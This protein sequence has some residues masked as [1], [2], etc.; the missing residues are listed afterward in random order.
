MKFTVSMRAVPMLLAFAFSVGCDG[1]GGTT[2]PRTPGAVAIVTGGSQSATVGAP[3][4]AAPS[5]VVTDTEGRPMSGVAVTFAVASGGGSVTGGSATTNGSGVATAGSWTLGT[6]AGANSLT[7]SAAGLPAVTFSATGIAGPPAALIVS[8]GSG[9]AAVAGSALGIAPAVLVRD[10]FANPVANVT[11][12]FAVASGS[13]S[14]AQASPTTNASGIASTPWILGTA[15]GTNTMNVSAG[16]LAPVTIT[17]TGIAGTAASVTRTSAVT[18]SGVVGGAPAELPRA[19][20]RDANGNGVANTPVVF[21]VTAGGGTLTGASATTDVSGTA[22]VGGWTLGTIAG[23]QTVTAT[24]P[25]LAPAIFTANA[26]PGAPSAMAISAAALPTG[27]AGEPLTVLPAVIMRDAFGN[28]VPNVTVTFTVVAGGGALGGAAPSTNVLGIATLTS[29]TLGNAVGSNVVRASATGVTPVN[30]TVAGI[31]GPPSSLTIGAGNAQSAA[32][33]SAVA[34]APSVFLRDRFG[35]AVS[36]AGVTFAVTGG[37]GAVTGA[38]QVTTTAGAATVGSWTLGAVAGSNTLSVQSAGV[39]AITFT[40]TGTTSP[41]PAGNYNITVRYATPPSARQQLAVDRAVARWEQVI[42]GDLQNIPANL[43]AGSCGA[44]SAALSETIDDLLIFVDFG[45][46]DGV[47]QILGQAGPCFIRTADGLPIIGTVQL[48]GADL[49]RLE[50]DGSIDAVV[51]HEIGHVLGIGSLWEN[52]G[53]LAFASTDTVSFTGVNT[54]TAFRGIPGNTFLGQST[55]VEN[56]VGLN[57]CGQG[58][59]DSHWRELVLGRELMTGFISPSGQTN[60]LSLMT[61]ESLGDMGYL[62]NRGAADPFILGAGL[63]AD[64]NDRTIELAEIKPSFR[65]RRMDTDGRIRQ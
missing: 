63:W 25:G 33:G 61:I 2:A 41:L 39:P 56:C 21:A 45:I 24:A 51:L 7:A 43:P 14:V 35:N 47:G 27:P 11:V 65:I 50:A 22:T 18:V 12:S 9:Q 6:S 57:G 4:A 8:A 59:R 34:I 32:P 55:P 30:F 42:T 36:N 53:L 60:P 29:W 16:T 3:V 19:V 10:A 38:T 62:V 64:G 58:T 13:G 15:A 17:A 26:A 20:V 46:I 40:A 1:G 23:T 52:Q 44:S 49:A 37:G 48:D 28:P 31:A 5:V 54:G